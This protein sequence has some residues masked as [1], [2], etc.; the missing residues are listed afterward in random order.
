MP[1]LEKRL[2][3]MRPELQETV[4]L[5]EKAAI[6]KSMKSFPRAFA[7]SKQNNTVEGACAIIEI[8][9]APVFA[10]LALASFGLL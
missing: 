9:P 3:K 5:E 1:M 8:R 4:H 7:K 6:S 10:S 2:A